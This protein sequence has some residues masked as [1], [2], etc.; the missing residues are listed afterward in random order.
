MMMGKG[1]GMMMMGK[2]EE[3]EPEDEFMKMD[4]ATLERTMAALRE[5]LTDT[6][7]KRNLMQIERD[8]VHDFYNNT[9]KEIGELESDVKNYDTKM[10]DLEDAHKVEIKVYTQKV[11]HLEYEHKKNCGEVQLDGDKNMNLERKYH[12]EREDEGR[13]EKVDY[14]TKYQTE[15]LS[16]IIDV[17]EKE[18]QLDDQL[19]QIKKQL[20][21]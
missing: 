18:Q 12:N 15:G 9:R 4:G 7:I 6:K 13:G 8:M 2:K 14:K 20:D 19:Q 5:K 17:E 3:P 11:K 10:Q 21:D 1:M 16:N